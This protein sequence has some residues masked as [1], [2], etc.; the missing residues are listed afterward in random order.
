MKT[1]RKGKGLIAEDC[2]WDDVSSDDSSDEEDTQVA[3]MAIIEEPTLALMAKIEEVPEEIP[4]QA[5]EASSSTTP[6]ASTSAT[7]S[8][9]QDKGI[10]YLDSGC[11]RHMTGSK[12]VLSNYREE[13]GP[14]VTFGGNGK[15]QTRGY[16]TLTNG[17]TTFKRVA[18][19]EGLMHNLLSISQLCDKNHKVSF[20]KKKCKV[21][22]RRKE[23]IL[24][25]VRRADIYIIN[26]NTSTDNF[27]FV[28][29]ASTDTNWLWHKRLSHLNFKTLNQLCIDNLVI[30]LPDFCYTKVS[31]CSACEKGK[32]TRASFK[33]KQI[34]SISSPLQLLHMD[35]FGPVNVQSIAGKKYTLVIVDE[36]SRYTWVFFLRSK[37]DAPE[38]IILFVRKMERLNNLT[39]RSIRSDHGTEFKNSTLE[40]FF[41]HKGI[42]QNFSSVRTPQQN[43]VAERRNRTLIE[44]ARSMLSEA[45]LATQFWAEAVNTACYTQNR[46]L[47]VKRFR[48][49][50]Y[51]LFRNRKPSIEHLHIFGCVCYILNNKDNLGKFDSKS[52]DGIFLGYSSIS[53]TYRVFNKR[54]QAI[55]ET[56]HVK[57]DESGPTFPHPHENSE[58]NQWADSFFQ[59][60]EP[61]IV[62]PC[63]APFP[64]WSISCYIG[65]GVFNN[66]IVGIIGRSGEIGCVSRSQV[67]KFVRSGKLRDLTPRPEVAG[68]GRVID[69]PFV[70]CL[71]LIFVTIIKTSTLCEGISIVVVVATVGIVYVLTDISMC[72]VLTGV[73]RKDIGDDMLSSHMRCG[74]CYTVRVFVVRLGKTRE[75][76]KL[77]VSIL[78][79]GSSLGLRDSG[80]HTS[81]V[82]TRRSSGSSGGG[83]QEIPDLRDIIASQVGEVLHSLLPGLFD[84]M[85]REMTELV[86]QQVQTATAGRVN[87]AGSSQT[88]HTRNVTFKDFMAC[89]PPNFLGEKGSVISSR[90]VSEVEGAF[91]TSFSPA[92]VKVRFAANL[93]RKA[94]KDWWNVMSSSRTPEQVAAMTWEEFKGLFKA[95]FEPQVEIERLT[96]EFLYMKQTTESVS[97]I[98]EKFLERSRFCPNYVADETMKMYRYGQMLKA[99][100]RE[101]VLMA[102]CTNFQQMFEKARSREIELER[103]GKRKKE[104]PSQVPSNKKFKGT[105]QRSEGKREYPRCSKCGR[106]HPGECRPSLITCYKC[107]KTGHSSRDCRVAARLCFRCFQPG[108]FAHECPNAAASTQIS[109]ATPLKAIEAGPAKKVEI[110][111]GRARVFQLTAEEAKVEPEVVTGIFPVNSKPALVL[112]DTGASKSFVSTSFCKGFSNVMGRLDEPLEVEIADEKS[113]IVRDIYRGNVIE[114][115]GVR[116]RVDLIPIP[117]KEINVVL[118]MSWLGRHGAWFDCEG[119]RVKI[120]NPS[121]GDLIITGNGMKRP[122]KTCSL[123]KARRYVKGGG[124]SYLVYV[125]EIAGEIKKKTVADV[126]VVRDFPDVFPEDLPGVP[127]ERQV[128]F[129]ID[130][131]P[132]AAPVAKA[133]Y[134]LAPPEMQELS[135]QLE[136]LLGKGFIRPSS[137]PWGAPILF[138]KKKDGSMRM[139]IDY[140]ELNKLTMK[141]R[142]PLPRIDDLFDQLQGAAWFSKIDL[143]SG[144]HQVKVREED[145]QKTAFRTRYG[146][147]EFVVMPFGLTNAPAVFMD[148]MNRVCRPMLDKSVIVFIDDI[149]IYSKTKEDHVVHL[150]EVLET[151]RRERLYAK[152]SKC[153]FWLQEVQFLGHLVNRE[154]I[155][156]DPAKI[157]AVMKWEVPKTPT[158]I[159]SFL[160]LAGY[161]RRFIQDFSK[162]VVP[163]TR[164][165][166]KNVKFVWGEEQQKAFELLRRKLC[167]A[168]IL[169]LPEGVDDMTVYCDASYHGLGCVLMQRGKVI[170]Y[171]SRQLKTHEVNY[172][173]HDL[174][175]AAVVFALKLWRH[176]LYGVKCTIYTDHKSLRYFLDQQNLN[177][178]QRRWLDVVKDYDCEIL[179]HPGKANVVADALSRKAHGDVLRVPLMRLTVTTSLIEL[180]K[181]S[182]IE[183]VKVENQRR[184]RIKGQLAQLVTDS[185]GLLTRSG[186]VWVPVSCEARQTLLDE[187]HKSKFS[188]HPGATKMYRDLKTDYWWPGM[189][190]DVARYVEKCLT[191]LRVKAEHQRPHG[192]LQPLDIP[193]WKWE[194]ITMDLITKLPRTVRNVDAIW[195]I[196]DRLTKSAHFIAINESSSSE[197]L[198][199]IYVKEIV[200]RHG[201]PVTIISDRDV[202][203]T[204]RFWSKFHEDLGTKLQLST[205]FHPQT[206]GQSERTIKTLEDMLRACVLDFGGSWDTY[207]PLAEFSYNNSYHA[208]IGM[209]PY[210]MLYGRRC[211]TPTTE[212]IELIRER[213]KTAQSRQ[214]SYADKRRSDLE[215]SVGD[216]VLL[217]VS[218]WKGVIRFR[219]RGKLGPRF[220]G[221]FKVIARVGK[222]AYRLELP[223]ELSQIHNT[224]HV[225]QLRKCLADEAA[226]ISIDDIQVDERLNYVERPIAVLE[227]KTKTLRNKEI[228]LVKVQWEHRKGSEWTWEPEA[229]M[230]A[231]YPELFQA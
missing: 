119:Q 136:E 95:E 8:S 9:S 162:I 172:P 37:S 144:Y 62:D 170:A 182:Q 154:G 101:F 147:F 163:L 18:Y 202:R 176:Y 38:E 5:P 157:E 187:A 129:G 70:V 203:F 160:G 67:A 192:K 116:F 169:T 87:E 196:V 112:F 213:L 134:R 43:G 13:R 190:R 200:A 88:G 59:V 138:V 183:A 127:P 221:P 153:D 11:S 106:N 25:G 63:N 103:Q 49:T 84:Q 73:Y 7:D 177:M 173:T 225:S 124:I 90:W 72:V 140:R 110:P 24:T 150:I 204:S 86:T 71:A 26:M 82:T 211:R 174:E 191:C 55:E 122:P 48:R 93:L 115:G 6:E 175:L 104:E 42:S 210:E 125:A 14:A 166:R 118:G 131:I 17:V 15:G 91:L 198:A 68:V 78:P 195:V 141:N 3:L 100:I 219:K 217:K 207:L 224:F 109:G 117:M 2:D 94:A 189:K 61:P 149:L 41:E 201:V 199:D 64:N 102:N 205:A 178:R 96:N 209:P 35:L 180:I 1:Q 54:R 128:E 130:L 208:S 216:D 44:A 230:R 113:V 4:P 39:V 66:T 47:I 222:V 97:E 56:I 161:Y 20:S 229:E 171:A 30:S 139:C 137:S 36:Y 80:I 111:K 92:E 16:G 193:V 60:P 184:E 168:P 58:I 188:I 159:R 214:K 120:R 155:K 164:L 185:R 107:G 65:M 40:T 76:G 228:G 152:F 79:K 85:K 108:H 45:N 143:R 74:L 33:S 226:H 197:K 23:V 34:S 12:S 151:L 21:K 223:P 98:T 206:D 27:C 142:Y 194:H 10:W 121:G 186:R 218:P 146:H 212:S 31:L 126:P 105:V 135:N 181:S 132:G 32:Q 145:V 167:K 51:E 89:Q 231:S 158:E 114:L 28:S 75:R 165:T 50:A 220:I 156:V 148:L 215:F 57:F 46:S 22:N 81:M 227:R 19:V 99:E 83:D 133:P 123:A 53:K 69:K 52:D 179:Y 77:E 29:R